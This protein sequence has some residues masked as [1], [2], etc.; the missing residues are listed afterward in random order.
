MKTSQETILPWVVITILMC[1]STVMSHPFH[2]CV[3]DSSEDLPFCDSSLPR[4]SR[5]VDLIARLNLT[6]KL[7]LISPSKAP[8]CGVDTKA[9]DRLGLP[10][11]KWLTETNTGVMAA[12]IQTGRCPTTFIGPMGLAASF[13]SSSWW[14]WYNQNI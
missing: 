2:G 5:V 11:Y 14:Y 1:A 6:E 13:N 8:Y 9:I 4:S 10:M 3:S 12:C 7:T